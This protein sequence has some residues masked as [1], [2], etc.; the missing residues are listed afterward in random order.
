MSF[1]SDTGRGHHGLK[2][3]AVI[4]LTRV[5]HVFFN[6][7]SCGRVGFNILMATLFFILCVQAVVRP[8]DQWRP[9]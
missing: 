4:Q 9:I 5:S 6:L 2:S 7:G 1:S 3:R 8:Q